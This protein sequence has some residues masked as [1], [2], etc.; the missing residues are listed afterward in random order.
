[1]SVV[2]RPA[3]V[4]LQLCLEILDLHQ[5]IAQRDL[6]DDARVQSRP[7]A[8]GGQQ[9]EQTGGHDLPGLER[10][11]VDQHLEQVL[12]RR[13]AGRQL[14]AQDGDRPCE[15][16]RDDLRVGEAVVEVGIG[17]VERRRVA[18][19]GQPA[20]RPLRCSAATTIW[21]ASKIAT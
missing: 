5:R 19:L 13:A 2:E 1:M 7:H 14:L 12:A 15:V 4:E 6:G 8:L 17:V 11:L 16:G 20:G 3:V 10:H 21:D 18:E 9:L